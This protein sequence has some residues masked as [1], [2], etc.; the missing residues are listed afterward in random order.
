VT[1]DVG[2]SNGSEYTLDWLQC[3]IYLVTFS[4]QSFLR[5]DAELMQGL[6]NKNTQKCRRPCGD[7]PYGRPLS[8]A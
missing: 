5:A 6:S 8:Y 7:I 1:Y 4:V 2:R 3:K